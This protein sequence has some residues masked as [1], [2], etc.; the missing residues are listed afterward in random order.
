[1]TSSSQP[2][3]L[4]VLV[5][6][7]QHFDIVSHVLKAAIVESSDI[8]C[9][10]IKTIRYFVFLLSFF[11]SSTIYVYQQLSYAAMFSECSGRIAQ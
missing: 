5:V 3:S 9:S 7:N 11:R 6:L 8:E 4:Q 1:M 10:I 2:F